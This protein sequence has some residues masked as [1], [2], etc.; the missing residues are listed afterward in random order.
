FLED[1]VVP[2]AYVY[3]D[4]AAYAPLDTAYIKG[5]E[6]GAS[7]TVQ[8]QIV[9][10]DDGTVQGN[11]QATTDADGNFQA[12]WTVCNC[13]NAALQLTATGQT[14]LLT[15]QYSFTDDSLQLFQ[16]A[17]RTIQVSAFNWNDTVYAKGIGL[18]PGFCYHVE[19]IRPDATVAATDNINSGSVNDSFTL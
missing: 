11:L 3:T 4:S 7:E 1:R 17:A 5:G 19:W 15:A 10:T 9:R 16:D 2:A 12:S 6:F 14:S 13:P 8:L 18:D